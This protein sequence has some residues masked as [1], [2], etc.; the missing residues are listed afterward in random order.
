MTDIYAQHL[1]AFANVSAYV[2]TKD[3]ERV[4]TIAFKYPKDGAG[5]LYA[6]VHWLGTEMIRGHAGGFG[7]DKHAASLADAANKLYKRPDYE[8]NTR[9]YA[10][11]S[12]SNFIYALRKNDGYSWERNLC[13]AGFTVLGAV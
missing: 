11:Q 2:I 6:Y 5:R 10:I 7:Y 1:A 8:E 3:G 4:A 12:L 13:D 9:K